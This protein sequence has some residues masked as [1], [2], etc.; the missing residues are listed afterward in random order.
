MKKA[1]RSAKSLFSSPS[2]L[3]IDPGDCDPGI[4]HSRGTK[5]VRVPERSEEV[6]TWVSRLVTEVPC[7]FQFRCLW[8]SEGGLEDAWEGQELSH[9]TPPELVSEA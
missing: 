9:S 6:S 1:E 5:A 7:G 4:F 3:S 2:F 8:S